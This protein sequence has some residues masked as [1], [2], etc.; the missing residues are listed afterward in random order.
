MCVKLKVDEVESGSYW[1]FLSVIVPCW[2]LYDDLLEVCALHLPRIWNVIDNCLE[3]EYK[4]QFSGQTLLGLAEAPQ[5]ALPSDCRPNFSTAWL[6]KHMLKVNETYDCWYTSGR[7][8]FEIFQDSHFGCQ[9]KD[10][11]LFEMTRRYSILL[12]LV[13]I[14]DTDTSST[15]LVTTVP[16]HP[17]QVVTDDSPKGAFEEK[18]I[19]TDYHVR[20]DMSGVSKNGL[21][22]TQDF[23]KNQIRFCGK[24]PSIKE[25]P[26]RV[27]AYASVI[28]L[29]TNLGDI[30]MKHSLVN[31]SLRFVF[32]KTQGSLQILKYRGN[33]DSTSLDETPLTPSNCDINP[34]M[35]GSTRS[36]I[37][38][39]FVNTDGGSINVLHILVDTPGMEDFMFDINHKACIIRG[40]EEEEEKKSV[41]L[42]SSKICELGLLNYKA[43]RVFYPSERR[44]FRCHYDYYWASIFKVEYR[45]SGQT[46]LGLAEAPK[47]ALPSDCRP[48]FSTA[49]LTKHMLKVNETYDCWYT[50]GRSKVE[51]FHDSYFGCQAKDPSLSEMMK[52]CSIL[53]TKMMQS[54]SSGKLRSKRMGWEVIIGVISGFLIAMISFTLFTLC[55]Q[56]LCSIPRAAAARANSLIH[57]VIFSRIFLLVTYFSIVSWL[58]IQ[59]E[60]IFEFHANGMVRRSAMELQPRASVGRHLQYDLRI[61]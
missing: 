55:G 14:M 41:D 25:F 20:I 27:R 38:K 54:W 1:I 17:F 29:N 35:I 57:R 48:N 26:E 58:A 33:L 30:E 10:P 11:S 18:Q 39:K 52:R 12:E 59:Y 50:S 56:L 9:A 53:F 4:D 21:T 51:I 15:F 3:V 16:N 44:K 32:H 31:G 13:F 23:E 45:F 61:K 28:N 34:L 8:K 36:C 6:T 19:V 43:K 22:I 37:I 40:T 60:N 42:R 47:E 46:F 49:W 7:S 2:L 24:V 5:E